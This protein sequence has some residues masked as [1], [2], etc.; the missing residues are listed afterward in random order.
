MPETTWQLIRYMA[1]PY[2]FKIALFFFITLIGVIGWTA[3]PF[4]VSLIITELSQDPTIDTK[5]WQ[6]VVLFAALRLCDELM[7]RAGDALMS[8]IKP[9]MIER[10]R[11][12]LFS[13]TLQKPHTFFVNASSGRIG[14]W[15]NQTT[16]TMNELVDTSIWT[17]WGQITSLIF[18]AIF[19]FAAHWMLGLL[20]AVWMVLLFWYNM[21]RGKT[22]GSLVAN[23]S[24]ERS[25]ASGMVVDSVSNATSVRVYNARAREQEQLATIQ[26]DIV[27]RWKRSWRHHL[28]TNTVKGQ[29]ASIVSILALVIV[30]WQ[31][32]IGNVELGSVVL[33]LAYFGSASSGL[34]QLA[35]ALDQYYRY[36]GTIQNALSGLAGEPERS[37]RRVSD[38][39]L[40][41]HIDLVLKD[42]DFAYADQPDIL[43][44]QD[45]NIDIK[46]GQKVGIVGHSGA[47]KS[48]FVSLLLGFY[49]PSRGSISINGID[50]RTKDP[51]FVRSVCAFVPQDTS[52]F[53]RTI[54]ENIVYAK[55]KA[56]EKEITNA[57]K[58]AEAFDFVQKL[59]DGIDTLIGE[60]GV[61]LSGGQRQRIAIA[62]A[63][64]KDSPLLVLDEATSA[65]DSVSEQAIQKALHTLMQKRTAVVIAHRL[66]TLK[67]LDRIIVVEEGTI[68]EDGTHEALIKQGG[69]YADLWR[70]QK[71]GFITE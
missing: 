58:K 12:A 54:R 6:L 42:V 1:R 50:I 67:H 27:R 60:R 62:R 38:K 66:S 41:K 64:L 32:S 8:T 7:W 44:L 14:H 49:E 16:T 26:G 29:S 23:E 65:L 3:A 43:V 52:L 22:F 13:Q 18:S 30:L 47:G 17:C 57:L 36:F 21:H 40:P 2:R 51:S 5:A 69:I 37:G 61:K 31:F 68:A 46:K 25:K 45:I 28:V 24:D 4:A 34:W 70:R 53:N 9:P 48:T 19:L 20:F 15:I 55:P 56:S 33:F 11:A 59:P 35:W 10:V 71:D 39:Q 63:I